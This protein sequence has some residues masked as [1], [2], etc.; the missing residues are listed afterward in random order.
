[1]KKW[2]VLAMVGAMA[3]PAMAQF[4]GLPY[5]D[6]AAA[7]EAGLVRGSAGAVVGDDAN[8]YGGRV[9]FGVMEGLALF[10]DLGLLDPDEGDTGFTYQGGG[11]YTLPL[12]LPVDVALRGS[13]GMASYEVTDDADADWLFVNFGALVSK[14]I[15]QF[16]PYGFLGMCYRDVEIDWEGVGDASEDETDVA[17]AGGALFALNEQFSLYGELA[18]IDDLF[19]GLGGRFQF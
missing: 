12:D 1:M 17:I 6:G 10:A 14:T 15:E 8:A 16:T 7:P 19:F 3:A 4:A 18:H 13:I 2:I 9:T 11:Q 5:A